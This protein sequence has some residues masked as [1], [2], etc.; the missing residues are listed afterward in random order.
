[1]GIILV[2]FTISGHIFANSATDKALPEGVD[3]LTGYRMERYRSP[4]PSFI[5]GATVVDFNAT[6]SLINQARVVLI[7]VFPPLGMGPD[8][9]DG[10]WIITEEHKTIAGAV[11]LPEVG[12]GFLEAKY[13]EYFSHHLKLLTEGNLNREIL[14]FCTADCWQSWNAARRAVRWGYTKVY[15]YPDGI[16]GWLDHDRELVPV[17]PVNFL[18]RDQMND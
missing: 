11:W 5:P 13:E 4:V 7:D 18:D 3:L 10:N 6:A 14:F 9:I 1:M 8:P 15:W 17:T 12:R 2:L 16:D